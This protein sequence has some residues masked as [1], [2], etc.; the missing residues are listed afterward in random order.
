MDNAIKLGYK[1]KSDYIFK[2]FVLTL[3]NLRLS[4]PKSNPLNYIAKLLLN[5]VY[6]RFGMLDSFSNVDI[7]DIKSYKKFEKDHAEDIINIIELDDKIMVVYRSSQKDLD[8]LLDNA[9]ETHNVS[10]PIA[11]AITA[12]ARV[13]M[14]QFKNNNDFNLYYTDTDSIY[15]DKPLDDSLV[16]SKTLGLMKLENSIDKA[17]FLSPKVY[18]LLTKDNNLIYK[19]K[20]LSH[21]IELTM[22][23]FEKLLYKDS[24][25]QKVQTK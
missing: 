23:D 1:F 14:S 4:Y 20:G 17:V 21:D 9:S 6:G 16:S 10:L 22:K 8:T 7:M 12:Y 13:H 24:F 3:Y 15:I 5:S 18:C 25:L 19:V 11:S 2:D